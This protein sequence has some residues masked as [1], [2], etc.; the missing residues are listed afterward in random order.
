MSSMRVPNVIRPFLPVQRT[1]NG[2]HFPPSRSF[3]FAPVK[4]RPRPRRH[5]ADV[6]K[7]MCKRG[8]HTEHTHHTIP[9]PWSRHLPMKHTPHIPF[10][11]P[12]HPPM[13]LLPLIFVVPHV[14]L[15]RSVGLCCAQMHCGK[16]FAGHSHDL[17]S[18]AC[19]F[20]YAAPELHTLYDAERAIFFGKCSSEKCRVSV[21]TRGVELV[22]GNVWRLRKRNSGARAL[23]KLIN[24]CDLYF[25][26]FPIWCGNSLARREFL[27]KMGKEVR[28]C[29]FSRAIFRKQATGKCILCAWPIARRIF[30]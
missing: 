24:R 17:P 3:S 29:A 11:W 30:G 16:S 14:T 2:M 19:D 6:V 13:A 8:E 27:G 26:R 20:L 5:E 23:C 12:R 1:V 18:A 25:H 22:K 9:F 4:G 28:E 10:P 21:N 7:W 15:N